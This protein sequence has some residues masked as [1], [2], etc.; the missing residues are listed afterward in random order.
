MPDNDPDISPSVVPADVTASDFG[1]F[2]PTLPLGIE[3]LDRLRLSFSR[4]DT[5]QNCG[6]KFRFAYIDKLPQKPSP[7]LSF[8]NSVHAALE[9]FFDRKLPQAPPLDVLLDT[10]YAKWDKSGFAGLPRDEQLEYYRHAQDVL[11]RYY[12]RVVDDFRLPLA[13]EQWFD[14]PMGNNVTIVGSIDRVDVDD[15]G[16]LHVIDY[17]TNRKAK[18]YRDVSRSLQL[19]LYALACEYLYGRLPKSVALDFVVPGVSIAVPVSELDLDKARTTVLETAEAIRAA[20]FT[21]E[22]NP[23]C[24]WCD[25]QALCPAWSGP[26]G[27]T[28]AELTLQLESDRRRL[29]REVDTFRTREEAQRRLCEDL[30]KTNKDDRSNADNSD[31]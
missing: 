7:H 25:F 4:I 12:Q 29:L 27:E 26:D 19:S 22:P 24:N 21:P 23:L 17:K 15:D 16:G 14:M 18:T 8:G 10:L 5:Y 6:L 2:E 11:R 31:R 30:M 1:S 28:L 20:A 9:S 3:Q 13:T